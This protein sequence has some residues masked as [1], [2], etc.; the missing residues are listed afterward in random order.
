MS[1]KGL[2]RRDHLSF[3]R[4]QIG[5]NMLRIARVAMLNSIQHRKT[6]ISDAIAELDKAKGLLNNAI[7]IAWQVVDKLKTQSKKQGYGVSGE[8]G[9]EGHVALNILV[10]SL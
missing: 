10:S 9:H 8:T 1:R 3:L 5:A 6:N 2:P 7:R 4:G